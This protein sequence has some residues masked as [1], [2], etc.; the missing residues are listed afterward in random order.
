MF[1]LAFLEGDP[2]LGGAWAVVGSARLTGGL[3]LAGEVGRQGYGNAHCK[4]ETCLPG[5]KS[6]LCPCDEFPSDQ[7]GS[8]APYRL[9]S[10]RFAL[11]GPRVQLGTAFYGHLLIGAVST[12]LVLPLV[13]IRPG[14]GAD[15]GDATAAFR[16]EVDYD[17]VP[18]Y[19]R[20]A[21]LSGLRILIGIVVRR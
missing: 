4:G 19:G 11:V 21:G 5:V 20:E 12:D 7:F 16:F 18:R 8:T 9:F 6:A 1:G 10:G 2:L 14:I 3:A 17:V 15:F 13:A